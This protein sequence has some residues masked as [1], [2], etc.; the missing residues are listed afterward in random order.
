MN[1]FFV[2]W[3]PSSG[4][5]KHEH[6]CFSDARKEAERLARE[7]IGKE[8]IVLKACS[9]SKIEDPV[10]TVIYQDDGIPF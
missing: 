4:Y 10:Q 6:C 7:N 2:V 9:K 5:T 8:F 1:A 3:E